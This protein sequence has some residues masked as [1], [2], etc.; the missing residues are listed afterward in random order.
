LRGCIELLAEGHNVDALLTERRADRWRGI[1][2]SGWDLKFN[3]TDD[4]FSHS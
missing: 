1:S 2:L 4:F 3:L